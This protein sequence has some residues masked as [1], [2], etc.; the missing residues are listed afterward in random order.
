MKEGIKPKKIS[1]EVFSRQ[2]IKKGKLTDEQ[3]I[4]IFH[5]VDVNA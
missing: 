3:R 1:S 5:T 4:S 2:D